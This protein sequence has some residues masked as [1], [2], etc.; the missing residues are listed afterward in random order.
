MSKVSAAIVPPDSLLAK[1]AGP[2]DYTDCFVRTVP[3]TVS[4]SEYITRFYSSWA[5]LPERKL[6]GLIG[7][8]ANHADIAAL[9]KG[10]TESFAA[11]DL[12]ERTD[13]GRLSPNC[14][15]RESGNPESNGNNSALD[16]RFR[17]DDKK[18]KLRQEILLRDFQGRTA[19][20]LA[21]S[22]SSG[23]EARPQAEPVG[24]PELEAAQDGA[25]TKLYFGSLVVKPDSALVKA[26]M[27]FHV[28]YAK[29]LLGG[30]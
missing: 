13:V 17:E 24:Q 12:V 26:L 20:W 8:G 19:S 30:V 28:A 29:V 23:C 10:R 1:H 4:L 18:G 7:R 16:P 22:S 27:G 2:D 6:L 5:F 9:A 3:G 21:V 15:S 25:S 11:W 14:H